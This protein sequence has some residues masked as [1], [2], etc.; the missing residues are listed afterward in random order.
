MTCGMETIDI[1]VPEAPQT[2]KQNWIPFLTFFFRRIIFCG[3]DGQ[4][5]PVS[6]SCMG[7]WIISRMGDLLEDFPASMNCSAR[8][9]RG[10]ER[11]R[12]GANVRQ[13]QTWSLIDWR[14]DWNVNTE[15]RTAE[16]TR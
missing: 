14:I 6:P 1:P 9:E 10:R 5:R 12:G 13:V 2:I 15:E 4:Q 7:N 8:S 16:A 11:G 3:Q